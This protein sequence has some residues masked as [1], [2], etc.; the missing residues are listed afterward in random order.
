MTFKGLDPNPYPEP[1][2]FSDKMLDPD[3]ESMNPDPNCKNC[4]YQKRKRR[5]I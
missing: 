4:T 1:A 5:R 2:W 3:P